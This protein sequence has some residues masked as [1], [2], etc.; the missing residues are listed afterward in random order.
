MFEAEI[1]A[2]KEALYKQAQSIQELSA[3]LEEER[4]AAASGTD[5]ALSTIFRLQQQKALE[6]MESNQYKRMMEA[7]MLHAE[8]SLTILKEAMLEKEVEIANLKFQVQSYRQSLLRLGISDTVVEQT[9]MLETPKLSQSNAFSKFSGFNERFRRNISMPSSWF[10]NLNLDMDFIEKNEPLIPTIPFTWSET[11]ENSKQLRELKGDL[12]LKLNDD[13]R[14]F[15]LPIAGDDE[16]QPNTRTSSLSIGGNS[17]NCGYLDSKCSFCSC[18]SAQRHRSEQD[19]TRTTTHFKNILDI[20]EIPNRNNDGGVTDEPCKSGSGEAM[21]EAKRATK[22]YPSM[23]KGVSMDSLQNCEITVRHSDVEE[24]KELVW[25]LEND[26]RVMKEEQTN[27][28]NEQL[29][30]LK[31]MH[32]QLMMMQSQ[33]KVSKRKQLSRQDEILLSSITEVML[34]IAL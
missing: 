28:N 26:Q 9:K 29:N 34:S 4:R 3:E 13:S 27:R 24:L 14:V 25:K 18:L 22:K 15:S 33:T 20:Y 6:K 10:H 32:E 5:E 30:L 23:G 16:S 7:K 8:E 2:L 21:I 31:Q 12:S 11:G 1:I 19:S 17:I